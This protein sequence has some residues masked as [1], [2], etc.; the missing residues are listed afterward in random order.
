[1]N[2]KP[3]FSGIST[4]QEVTA[5]MQINLEQGEIVPYERIA[6]MSG[7]RYGTSRFQTIVHAWTKR[8]FN[9]QRMQH[10]SVRGIG[11]RFL[12]D[13][14]ALT[15]GIHDSQRVASRERKIKTRVTKIN[16]QALTEFERK[17]RDLLEQY[18]RARDREARKSKTELAAP[19]PVGAT[20][21]RLAG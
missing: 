4:E 13:G 21:V 8:V 6:K 17:Q 1:M 15:K 7:I 14:Q 11:I 19:K 12:T 16:T 9:E 3:P 18:L 20:V 10:T 5:L 2:R